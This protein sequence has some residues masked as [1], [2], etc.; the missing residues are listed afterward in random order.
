MPP[1]E[2]PTGMITLG[3]EDMTIAIPNLKPVTPKP[4]A[5]EPPTGNITLGPEDQTIA[6][7]NPSRS[8]PAATMG[9]GSN[10]KYSPPLDTGNITLGP[11]DQTIAI[12]T[13]RPGTLPGAATL[14]GAST[15]QSH[16][17]LPAATA[18]SMAS[19]GTTSK[20]RSHME[21]LTGNDG[22]I[23][24]RYRL[25]DKLG[26]GGFGVVYRAEQVKPIQRIVA[27]KIVK[28][29][30]ASA[31]IL[32]RFAIEQR[33]LAIME[34]PNIARILDA[35]ETDIGAPFFVMEMV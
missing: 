11:E 31:D 26:E 9:S 10:Q 25:L 2:A 21:S 6:I 30:V 34:H 16:G 7:P 8:L 32:G 5:P 20:P 14:P 3:P 15:M 13:G 17:G 29:G 23:G 33:T 35:G 27:I 18:G 28:A 22:W 12:S 19:M 4:P 1:A 24:D